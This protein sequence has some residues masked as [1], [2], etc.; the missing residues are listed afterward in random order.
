LKGSW[1][2]ATCTWVMPHAEVDVHTAAF[3]LRTYQM[4][5]K[6]LKCSFYN[7]GILQLM[8]LVTT[9]ASGH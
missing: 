2:V 7:I 9:T 5:L 6:I 8:C 3:K 1:R 4:N